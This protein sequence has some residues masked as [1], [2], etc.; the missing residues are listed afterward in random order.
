MTYEEVSHLAGLP[1]GPGAAD[2]KGAVLQVADV[3]FQLGILEE[4]VL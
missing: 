1:L 4:S 2:L 3:L